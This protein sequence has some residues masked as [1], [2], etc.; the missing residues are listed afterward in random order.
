MN[1]ENL[2]PIVKGTGRAQELQILS[3]KKKRQNAEKRR[4][5][6]SAVQQVFCSK[7]TVDQGLRTIVEQSFGI[8]L[9]K[10]APVG[11]IAVTRLMTKALKDGNYKAVV[12]LAKLGGMHFDQSPEGLGGTENPINVASAVKVAPDRVKQISE[13]LENEC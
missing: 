1:P 8:K 6:I 5:L 10:T 3:A 2:N 7:K 13:M 11:L 9:G 12:E 4:V